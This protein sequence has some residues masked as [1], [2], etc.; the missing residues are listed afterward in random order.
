LA[1]RVEEI[2]DDELKARLTAGREQPPTPWHLFRCDIG[3]LS[4][5]SL[6]D[7]PDFLVISSWHE[8]RGVTR[9]ER[10]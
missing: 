2:D 9:V 8:G 6:P 10:R 1:G 3:E 5:V 4:V 7:P